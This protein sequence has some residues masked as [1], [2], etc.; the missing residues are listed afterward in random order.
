M[1]QKQRNRILL[2]LFFGVLMGALDIAI[3]GPAL[4]SIRKQ[5]AVDERTLAWMFSSYVLMQLI[6]TPWMAKLSD[7]YGRRW[8]YMLDIGLFALGSLLVALAP[9]FWVV[10][11]GRAIQGFGA[12]GIFPVASAVIG[13]TFPPEKRGSALGMIGAVFGLAF[14]IGPLLG[15]IV[16]ALASWHWLFLINL[17][18]ALAI[19]ISAS[20]L[21]PVT[22]PA[23]TSRLDSGGLV[24]LSLFLISLTIGINQLD[25]SQFLSS[26]LQVQVGGLLGIALILLAV[27]IRYEQ[28]VEAPL[29][30]TRLFN[31]RQLGLAYWLSWG[32]GFTEAS[33]VFVPLMAVSGLASQGIT[34]KNAT[35]LLIPAVLAMVVGAPLSGRMLDRFGSRAVVVTGTFVMSLGFLMLSLLGSSLFWFVFSGLWIGLGLSA[36]LGAPIRYI[37]LNEA[38]PEERSLAQGIVTLFSSTGQLIG[39][40]FMGALAASFGK[41]DVFSGYRAAFVFVLFISLVMLGSATLLKKR[42]EELSRERTH[43]NPVGIAQNEDAPAHS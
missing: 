42:Q 21:L 4:P 5:F 38:L 19:L 34:E 3:L 35:W 27:L 40:A 41:A 32:A 16:L 37:M 17:P 30:P 18:I 15:G 9:A 25:S 43:A 31:R 20:R 29:L 26:L 28:R 8:I 22:R 13:D 2:V 11:L 36:L 6:S 10:L 1:D 39:S 24:L 23:Q 7:L 12:G 14:L 33:L